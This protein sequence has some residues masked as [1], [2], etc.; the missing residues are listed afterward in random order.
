MEIRMQVP[1]KIKNRP[2]AMPV[3]GIYL[4]CK[5]IYKRDNCIP[6]LIAALFTKAKLWNQLRCPTTDE[7]IKKIYM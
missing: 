7:R 4:K 5:S 3:L 2:P 1:Q 6:I